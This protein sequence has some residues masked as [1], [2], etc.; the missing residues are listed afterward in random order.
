MELA[1]LTGCAFVLG[2]TLGIISQDFLVKK[3]LPGIKEGSKPNGTRS[4]QEIESMDSDQKVAFIDAL[5]RKLSNADKN[6][7]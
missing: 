6:R 4:R 5:D 3:A 7:N 1:I 2:L